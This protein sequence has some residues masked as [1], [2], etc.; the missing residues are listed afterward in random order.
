MARR[1]PAKG[2]MTTRRV[3]FEDCH[4][5]LFRLGGDDWTSPAEVLIRMGSR[6]WAFVAD[7]VMP[8]GHPVRQTVRIDPVRKVVVDEQMSVA[9]R[10]RGRARPTQNSG[11]GQ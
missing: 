5:E 1:K 10:L 9:Y 6:T 4:L 3:A 2:S 11:P 7:F 8:S